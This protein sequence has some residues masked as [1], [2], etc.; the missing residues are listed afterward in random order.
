MDSNDAFIHGTLL[1]LLYII[2]YILY[3]AS[4]FCILLYAI[5]KLF[6]A[7]FP[8]CSDLS[9]CPPIKL[10][11]EQHE[12]PFLKAAELCLLEYIGKSS[13]WDIDRLV[14]LPNPIGKIGS[15]EQSGFKAE[16]KVYSELEQL[17]HN[18]YV[19]YSLQDK[20]EEL[21][22]FLLIT[23]SSI[24]ILEVKAFALKDNPSEK[25][26]EIMEKTILKEGIPLTQKERVTGN[27][28]KFLADHG[29]C[30]SL[31][32]HFFYLYVNSIR[33]KPTDCNF[34]LFNSNILF[35]DALFQDNYLEKI[36][37][38]C[39]EGLD[40]VSV[41]EKSRYAIR[42]LLARLV[43]FILIGLIFKMKVLC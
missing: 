39:V 10:P 3:I 13:L 24:I 28:R 1:L 7:I 41:D 17:K 8:E 21:S 40:P 34:E 14:L 25:D 27:I 9:C 43:I 30:D 4:L 33:P 42:T 37:E 29:C 20:N 2:L 15:Q 22:D 26:Y 23:K 35:K 31:S 16:Y 32:I 18:I 19:F 38:L 12:R 5:S 11:A 36:N 6:S